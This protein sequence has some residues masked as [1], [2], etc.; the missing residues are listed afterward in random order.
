ML[1]SKEAFKNTTD[2]DELYLHRQLLACMGT[3]YSDKIDFGL[4]V[5]GTS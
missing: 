4:Q 5:S 3:K 1:Y 2:P